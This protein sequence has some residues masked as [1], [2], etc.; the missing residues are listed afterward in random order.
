MDKG[1]NNVK[2]CI[3]IN[4]DDQQHEQCLYVTL[5]STNRYA[6]ADGKGMCRVAHNNLT[7]NDT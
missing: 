2:N 3:M 7:S 4:H 5:Q 6:Q 1:G